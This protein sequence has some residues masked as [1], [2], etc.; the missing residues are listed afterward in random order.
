MPRSS[1]RWSSGAD[2]SEP[3]ETSKRRGTSGSSDS[4]SARTSASRSRQSAL[5]Q[6]ARAG[7]R[8]ARAATRRRRRSPRR[9]TRAGTRAPRRAARRARCSEPSRLGRPEKNLNSAWCAIEPRMRGVDL[10]VHRLRVEQPLDEPDR[11]AAGERLQLG[12]AE[13]RA[14]REATRAP[15]G[16]SAGVG[17]S[18][19]PSAR[20]SRRSQ[21][22]ARAIAL[23]RCR[24][25]VDERSEPRAGARARS[26]RPRAA[27]RARRAPGGASSASGRPDRSTAPHVVPERARLA[28]RAVVGRRLAH[29][30]E[31]PRRRACTRCRR[32]SGRGT[33]GSALRQP[34]VGVELT[35]PV[36]VEERRA[37]RALREDA[38]LEPEHE[39]DLRPARARAQQVEHRDVPGADGAERGPARARARRPAPRPRA[40]RQARASPRARRAASSTRLVRAQ[41]E[42]GG[43]GRR[44]RV[45]PVRRPEHRAPRARGPPRSTTAPHAGGRGRRAAGRAASRSR[46]RAR[47]GERIAA[48]AQPPFEEVGVGAREAGVRRADEAEQVAAAAAEPRVAEEREQRMAE[49]RLREPERRRRAR[50]G[51]RAR[52]RPPRAARAPGRAT[53][54]RRGSPPAACRT[55]ASWRISSATSSSV[56]RAPAPSRKRIAPSDAGGAGGEPSWKSARSRW[57]S[58]GCA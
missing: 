10:G 30:V 40:R 57:A 4:A 24:S 35:A 1:P 41:V 55:G 32:G 6:L 43:L 28:R 33:T 36:V 34:R 52:R 25:S 22:F 37:L 15:P 8:S 58:A 39:H 19:A 12:D 21:P 31:P 38:L 11:R 56:A 49:R 29:E 5:A 53:G 26:A 23:G 27:R 47:S 54:R 20:P 7:G 46:P 44:R 2:R 16:R 50:T 51:R 18:K 9:D 17:R 48:P 14:R 45:E 42:T 13:R 3:N